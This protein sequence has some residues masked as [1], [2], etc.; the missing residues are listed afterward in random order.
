M[1]LEKKETLTK[2]WQA[3]AE[4]LNLQDSQIIMNMKK[5]KEKKVQQWILLKQSYQ[6][7]LE[8]TLHTYQKIDGIPLWKINRKLNRLAVKGIPKEVLEKGKLVIN[9][10]DKETVGTSSEHQIKMIER[11]IDELEGFENL[12]LSHFF[13][14]K[15]NYI[16]KKV[17]GVVT[18]VIEIEISE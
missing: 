12:R 5:L 15:P 17:F 8:E 4:E 18:R 16:E 6:A 9:L 1:L 13:Q 11:T 7:R 10:P 14:Y 3:K 2:K